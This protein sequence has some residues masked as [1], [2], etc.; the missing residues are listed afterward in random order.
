M[1]KFNKEE[2]SLCKQVAERWRK[3]KLELGDWYLLLLLNGKEQIRLHAD[4]RPWIIQTKDFIPLWTISDCLE[5]LRERGWYI[6]ACYQSLNSTELNISH[7]KLPNWK[8]D[9]HI[10]MSAETFLEA[11][12]KAVLAVFEE[13]VTSV[14]KMLNE[15]GK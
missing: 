13:N 6:T 4:L 2:I 12:L 7:V 10:L 9:K 15:E 11:C 8:I 14:T 3:D 1:I 5:F